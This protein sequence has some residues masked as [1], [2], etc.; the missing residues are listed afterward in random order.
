[1][2]RQSLAIV[3]GPHGS[4]FTKQPASLSLYYGKSN[5]AGGD[6]S[7]LQVWYQPDVNT[8]WSPLST[9]VQAK[10]FYLTFDLYHFSN[11][12]VAFRK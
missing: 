8:A 9:A 11:Y 3:F 6:P 12:A 4:T 5:L 7:N 2:A 10:G 1:V